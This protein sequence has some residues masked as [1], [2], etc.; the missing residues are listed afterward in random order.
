MS[1][2]Y[3]D[4][5]TDFRRRLRDPATLN[6]KLFSD[7]EII[8][9]FIDAT[10]ALVRAGGMSYVSSTVSIKSGTT[11]YDLD[12]SAMKVVDIRNATGEKIYATTTG[13]LADISV[14]WA[15]ETGDIT[16]FY[17]VSGG[18]L[19]KVGFYKEPIADETLTVRSWELPVFGRAS[20]VMD[21]D[22]L[23]DMLQEKMI[24]YALGMGFLKKRDFE[25]SEKYLNRFKEEDLVD[26]ENF[27]HRILDGA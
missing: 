10:V 9:H 12:C 4:L 25:M 11:E 19:T 3:Q 6:N 8:A 2:T 27:V 22:E 15:T 26:V 14:E 24:K 5:V 20:K 13:A 7:T 23:D 16:H 1:F 21:G 17:P 18:S